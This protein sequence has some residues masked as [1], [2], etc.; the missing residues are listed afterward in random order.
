MT[1]SSWS[2]YEKMVLAKLD[3]LEEGLADVREQQIL[4]RIDVSNLKVKAGI[5]GGV[6]GLVPAIVGVAL[7]LFSGGGTA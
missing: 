5:W 3:S 4:L 7:M 6:A 2:A 1:D